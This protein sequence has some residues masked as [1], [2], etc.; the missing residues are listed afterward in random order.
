V[1]LIPAEDGIIEKIKA[2]ILVNESDSIT[3]LRNSDGSFSINYT[4][5]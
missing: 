4:N 3:M 5:M 2:G 1:A